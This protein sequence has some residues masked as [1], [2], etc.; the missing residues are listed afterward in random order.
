MENDETSPIRKTPDLRNAFGRGR[1]SSAALGAHRQPETTDTVSPISYDTAIS[2]DTGHSRSINTSSPA[3]RCPLD[4]CKMRAGLL[5]SSSPVTSRATSPTTAHS[6][7]DLERLT[8]TARP[9]RK[10]EVSFR[11]KT[12][13]PKREDDE[14]SG[15]V[16]RWADVC[17]HSKKRQAWNWTRWNDPY[18]AGGIGCCGGYTQPTSAARQCDCCDKKYRYPQPNANSVTPQNGGRNSGYYNL[19]P[20]NDIPFMQPPICPEDMQNMPNVQTPVRCHARY[21]VAQPPP[22][23]QQQNRYDMNPPLPTSG[24]HQNHHEVVN[25]APL[26]SGYQLSRYDVANLAQPSRYQRNGY[27]ALN[28]MVHIDKAPFSV[29]SRKP[30]DMEVKVVSHIS[31]FNSQVTVPLN[32]NYVGYT[33]KYPQ[34]LVKP[35]DGKHAGTY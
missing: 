35:S 34:D 15:G 33:Q 3:I 20:V 5:A 13:F 25:S 19:P 28:P 31:G 32:T 9:I 24:Y 26:P 7:V 4:V 18:Y 14:C 21:G 30:S 12:T 10:D 1:R 2:P 11:P 23:Q 6:Q 22:G 27:E 29:V 16:V 8:E 17:V